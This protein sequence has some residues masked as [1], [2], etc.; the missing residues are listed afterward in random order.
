VR[1]VP[2]QE[3]A[4]RVVAAS[5]ETQ[6]EG[7]NHLEWPR[8]SDLSDPIPEGARTPR[9]VLKFKEVC[10]APLTLASD[11]SDSFRLKGTRTNT[12]QNSIVIEE[13]VG[14]TGADEAGTVRRDS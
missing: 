5:G 10:I 1:R 6:R 3:D 7:Q 13:G 9:K 8:L 11:L 2:P 12:M 4:E 14:I